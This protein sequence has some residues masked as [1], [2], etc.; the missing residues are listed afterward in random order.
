MPVNQKVVVEK[1]LQFSTLSVVFDG[2]RNLVFSFNRDK[3]VKFSVFK[4][5]RENKKN[6]E[7]TEFV[8]KTSF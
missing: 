1:M 5:I 8:R 7:K 3:N 6:Y 4:L 2:K